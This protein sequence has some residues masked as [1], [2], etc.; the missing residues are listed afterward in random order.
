MGGIGKPAVA[1]DPAAIANAVYDAVG[2][3]LY[4]MPFTPD[5]VLAALGASGTSTVEPTASPAG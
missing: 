4:E 3:W 1:P 2:I 5:R